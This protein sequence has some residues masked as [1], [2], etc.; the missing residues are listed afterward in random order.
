MRQLQNKLESLAVLGLLKA[1]VKDGVTRFKPTQGHTF[2]AHNVMATVAMEALDMYRDGR[3][4]TWII[5]D[6]TP[7]PTQLKVT[8]FGIQHG[9]TLTDI[10]VV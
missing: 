5:Q 6:G 1:S 2:Y 8:D 7:T 10:K 3:V 9:D 4:V